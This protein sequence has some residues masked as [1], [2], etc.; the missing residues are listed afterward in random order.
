M[1]MKL[2]DG[3]SKVLTLS[4]DDGTVQDIRLIGI[5]DKYGIKGTFN[6]NTGRYLPEE[7]V[8][9]RYYGKLKL[10]EAIELYTNSGHEVAVH[11]YSHPYLDKMK[12]DEMLTEILEDR[13][14]IEKQYGTLARG[15]AYPFGAYNDDVITCLKNCGICYSRTIKTTESFD[16]P[17]NWLEWDPT[18]HHKNPRLMEMAKEFLEVSSKYVARNWLFYVWGHSFEFDKKDNWEIIE[19]FAE[20]IGGKEDV[21]YATNIEIYDYVK[22]YESLQTSVDKK[23]IYNPSV[24]DVWFSDDTKTYCIKAGETLCL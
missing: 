16:F 20:Y 11:G 12:T 5:L 17:K 14:N 6:I 8:R 7:T 19:Q 24:M 3:K 9:T 21:W 2:K 1:Y 15:M 18:C 23:I 13:R 10:S 4:Y 22:A